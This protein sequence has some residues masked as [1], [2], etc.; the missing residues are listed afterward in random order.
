MK[1]LIVTV[2]I[3]G[4]LA[5]GFF[6]FKIYVAVAFGGTLFSLAL[7]RSWGE[8]AAAETKRLPFYKLLRPF[9]IAFLV[10]L[11]AYFVGRLTAQIL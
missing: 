3:L 4:A 7:D 10:A 2:C 5:A 8:G 6:G 11:A 9:P 1:N